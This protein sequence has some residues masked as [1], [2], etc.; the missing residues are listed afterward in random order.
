MIRP[1]FSQPLYAVIALVLLAMASCKKS[2]YE[3]D[4]AK[5]EGPYAYTLHGTKGDGTI[6]LQWQPMAYFCT[7]DCPTVVR[8]NVHKYLLY[9]AAPEGQGFQLYGEYPGSEQEARLVGLKNDEAYLFRLVAVGARDS[10]SLSQDIM[11]VPGKECD[12]RKVDMDRAVLQPAWNHDQQWLSFMAYESADGG[13]PV[14]SVFLQQRG[15]PA[16]LHQYEASQPVWSP[17]SNTLAYV[18]SRGLSTSDFRYPSSQLKLYDVERDAVTELTSGQHQDLHPA[19]A[20]DGKSVVFLSDRDGIQGQYNL[21]TVEL[22]TG[23][24]TQLTTYG[25]VDSDVYWDSPPDWSPDGKQII[26]SMASSSKDEVFQRQIFLRNESGDIRRLW[27]D[28]QWQDENPV[29]S[30]DGRQFAFLSRRSG[31]G[32]IWLYS[33]D[34]GK[35]TQLTTR[36]SD[37]SLVSYGKAS[38]AWSP[39]GEKLYFTAREYGGS[40]TSSLFV[41]ALAH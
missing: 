4:Y 8:F 1:I 39:D 9:R 2:S 26:F 21:W 6:L 27:V 15:Q 3:L 31:D 28:S 25:G 32:E 30:P 37:G 22:E 40:S 20:P 16:A 17:V 24:M 34:S 13:H 23:E 35:F 38:L 33:I 12:V 19:W 5:M 29:W 7:I 18:S 10:F 11:V 36:E 41:L 14:S